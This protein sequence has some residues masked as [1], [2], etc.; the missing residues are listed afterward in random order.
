MRTGSIIGG[1]KN[2]GTTDAQAQNSYKV[3]TCPFEVQSTATTKTSVK[4]IRVLEGNYR[5]THF[6]DSP[7][8][9]NELMFSDLKIHCLYWHV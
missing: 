1:N 5:K 8:A 9:A 6:I 4:I 7:A 2:L 3:T